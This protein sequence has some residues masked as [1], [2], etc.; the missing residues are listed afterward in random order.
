MPSSDIWRAPRLLVLADGA[1]LP[2]VEAAEIL[3]GGYFSADTFRIRAALN[4][5]L[6][7]WAATT[8]ASVDVQFALDLIGGYTSL[9]QGQVDNLGIDPI[10]GTLTLEG[11]DLSAVLIEA[12]TQE[13]FANQT[14]SDIA[15]ALAVRHGL[16]ADVQAT[17][18]PAGRFWELE[19]DSLTLDTGTRAMTEWD[20]LA[21]LAGWEGFDLWVNGGALHFRPPDPAAAPTLLSVSDFVA[22]RLYRA[23]T[24]A[25][26]I[27]VTVKSWHSRLGA[28]CSETAQTQRG[29]G[30]VRDY[31]FVV[32]NLTPDAALLLA[33]RKLDE[34]TRHELLLRGEM[35]GELSLSPR[36]L[37]QLIGS[38]SAFDRVWRVDA[39]ERHLSMRDGFTQ[40]VTAHAST[41]E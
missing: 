6:A 10:A 29:S 37:I 25:G 38:N 15:T 32:P 34:L 26:D 39:V 4:G 9:L 40:T 19:H 36:G 17:M 21:T 8:A 14:S 22:L 2:G 35:P 18:T 23:L 11:R 16:A 12:R 3:S 33:Q 13:T 1:A 28:G 7:A 30:D 27:S 20:L 31:V 41:T 24:F 5:T